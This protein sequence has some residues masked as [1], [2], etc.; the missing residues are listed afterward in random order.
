MTA[1]SKSRTPRGF[2]FANE[3]K[4]VLF[5]TRV[6]HRQK[7]GFRQTLKV[8]AHAQIG[9]EKAKAISAAL[10]GLCQDVF[11]HY[12]RNAHAHMIGLNYVHDYSG[13]RSPLDERFMH[14]I[15]CSPHF[16]VLSAQSGFFRANVLF[17]VSAWHRENRDG[18]T[19]PYTV[20]G[21]LRRCVED[22]VQRRLAA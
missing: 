4:F 11:E 18:K 14:E 17:A 5:V 2:G 19:V 12:I 20:H 9:W 8:L 3:M 13:N 1:T 22:F 6:C 15:E 7:I 16:G 21:K 10:P